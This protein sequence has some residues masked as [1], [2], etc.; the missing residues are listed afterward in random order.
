MLPWIVVIFSVKWQFWKF[1]F[2]S[3]MRSEFI[4]IVVMW[5]F[6]GMDFARNRVEKPFE[7]PS[8]RIC[9]GFFS[10]ISSERIMP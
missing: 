4:S 9:F 1:F 5:E 8:S 10:E 6:F 7:V 2:A 3:S